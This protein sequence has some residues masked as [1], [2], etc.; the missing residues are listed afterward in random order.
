MEI[1]SRNLS[2]SESDITS[3]IVAYKQNAINFPTNNAFRKF[4][5]YANTIH[6]SKI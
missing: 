2:F 3:L 1:V 4:V 6:Q 5:S